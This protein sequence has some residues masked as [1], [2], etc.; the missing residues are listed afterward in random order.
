MKFRYLLMMLCLAAPTGLLAQ[1]RVELEFEQETYLPHEPLYAN[2]RIYNFS[3]QTLQ[4]GKDAEWLSF[5]VEP[6]DGGVVKQL[7]NPDVLGEFSLPNG[8]RAKKMVNLAEAFE[9]TDF[10]RYYVTAVVRVADWGGAEYTI[11]KPKAVGINSGV[12]LWQ[13]TFGAPGEE[14]GKPEFRKFH[15]V[16]AN[17]VKQLS[18]YARVTDES[19]RESYALANL[20]PLVGFSK[21]HAQI[22]KWSNLHVFYQ[23]AARTF[24]YFVIMP[25]G[26]ILT[27]QTWELGETKPGLTMN[28]E[29]RISVTGGVRRISA[30]DLPPPE[31]LSEQT[32]PSEAAATEGDKR[33][34]AEKA[35]K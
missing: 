33:I 28:S 11:P 5:V 18:L 19:E 2:V 1:L 32:R 26:A 25:D 9:L 22:D 21:P 29:G 24:R 13:T 4:L 17:H 14:N 30:S 20:G 7:K 31:L 10:G 16:Q 27:R 35:V 15:L 3:G 23:D 34:D 12:T 8:S 6:S